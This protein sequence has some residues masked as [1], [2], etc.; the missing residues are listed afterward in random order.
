MSQ[1]KFGAVVVVFSTVL[2]IGYGVLFSFTYPLVQMS[3]AI[4]SLCALAGLVTCL[5]VMALWRT[6]A[7]ASRA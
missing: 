4:V 2:A 7:G 1:M 5:G 6:V 3:G